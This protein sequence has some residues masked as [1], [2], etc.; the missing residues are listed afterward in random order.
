[1]TLLTNFKKTYHFL[2]KFLPDNEIRTTPQND[3]VTNEA[4][5]HYW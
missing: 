4:A 1:M 5:D 2:P 3:E